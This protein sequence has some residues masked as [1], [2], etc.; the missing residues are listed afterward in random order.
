MIQ[1]YLFPRFLYKLW[2]RNII[3]FPLHNTVDDLRKDLESYKSEGN[4][5][6]K[7]KQYT[8]ALEFYLKGLN[9]SQRSKQLHKEAAILY[10]NRANVFCT[11]QKYEEAL[12]SAIAATSCDETYHKV[13]ARWC[14]DS[15]CV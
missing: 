6:L 14:N 1:Y 9:V 13:S 11:Q 10:S 7:R 4:E 5:A 12:A 8:K 3:I 2:N 15:L